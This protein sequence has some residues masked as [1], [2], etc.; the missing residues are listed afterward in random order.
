MDPEKHTL[1]VVLA[2]QQLLLELEAELADCRAQLEAYKSV[3]K[4]F[5][6]SVTACTKC[7]KYFAQPPFK[8]PALL[9]NSC[10]PRGVQMPLNLLV[11][12]QPGWEVALP[13]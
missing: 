5:R 8:E 11:Q 1:A 13:E 4:R 7:R 9:C 2:Q 3:E 6:I 12:H 10:I